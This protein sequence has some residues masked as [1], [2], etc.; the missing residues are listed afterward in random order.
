MPPYEV[1]K[2]PYRVYA[3]PLSDAQIEQ[4]HFFCP[5]SIL[6]DRSCDIVSGTGNPLRTIRLVIDNWTDIAQPKESRLLFRSL[7][8][9]ELLTPLHQCS[10]LLTSSSLDT[11]RR[12]KKSTPSLGPLIEKGQQHGRGKD[13]GDKLGTLRWAV[14]RRINAY[15]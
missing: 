8:T 12:S 15:R 10:C 13:E 14:E 6:D 3:R 11:K 1:F 7:A 2:R 4:A 5:H 9:I